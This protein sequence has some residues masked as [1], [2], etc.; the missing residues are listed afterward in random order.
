MAEPI[1]LA[2]LHPAVPMAER[3]QVLER[4]REQGLISEAEYQALREEIL[5]E[6]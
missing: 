5:D 4:M 6:I 1:D 2:S 3:L